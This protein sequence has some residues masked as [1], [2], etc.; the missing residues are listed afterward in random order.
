MRECPWPF[1]HRKKREI[2]D[3]EEF[4]PEAR[5]IAHLRV[6]IIKAYREKLSQGE[7]PITK[8][9]N[10]FLDAFNAGML[11][12]EAFAKPIRLFS[13]STLYSWNKLYKEGGFAAL[14]PRYKWIPRPGSTFAPINLTPRYTEIIIPG[15]PTAKAKYVMLLSLRHQWKGPPLDCPI[16]LGIFYSMPIPKRTGMAKRMKILKDQISHTCTPLLGSLNGF[17]VEC[18]EGIV[19]KNHSQIVEFHSRKDFR[20]GPQTRILIRALP[21]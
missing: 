19:F 16:R 4:H 1:S 8:I 13:R 6:A 12:P 20:C 18:M 3:T 9:I 11:Q 10:E 15:P 7:K 14:I 2:G 5:T 21:R 17:V